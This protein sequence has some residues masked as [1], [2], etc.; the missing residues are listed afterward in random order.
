MLMVFVVLQIPELT[1]SHSKEGSLFQCFL[2]F[3]GLMCGI[4]IMLTIA[5]YEHDLKTLF[6]DQ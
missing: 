6:D 2:H 5:V 4:L 1:S 3:A